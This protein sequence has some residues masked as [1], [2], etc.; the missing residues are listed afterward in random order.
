MSYQRDGALFESGEFVHGQR[1][2]P[3]LKQYPGNKGDVEI[4]YEGG[5]EVSRTRSGP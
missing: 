3:W 2:G 1:E 5:V 4:V